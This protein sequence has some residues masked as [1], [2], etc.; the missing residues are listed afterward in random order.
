[1]NRINPFV[2]LCRK[3]E[4]DSI[5][6]C[7]SLCSKTCSDATYEQS[8]ICGN[9][10]IASRTDSRGNE[11]QKSTKQIKKELTKIKQ[12]LDNLEDSKRDAIEITKKV[13]L[14]RDAINKVNNNNNDKINKNDSSNSNNNNKNNNKRINDENKSQQS[15]YTESQTIKVCESSQ[16]SEYDLIN[17]ITKR[18]DLIKTLKESNKSLYKNL[19]KQEEKIT[20]LTRSLQSSQAQLRENRKSFEKYENLLEENMM[21]SM[22][23][24]EFQQ[25]LQ[26]KDQTNKKILQAAEELAKD[27][28]ERDDINKRLNDT[29]IKLEETI[30]ELGE[31]N[32][33]LIQENN[34]L[35][36]NIKDK[37]EKYL[38]IK[39]KYD[40]V[41]KKIDI[42]K[43]QMQK[44]QLVTSECL[45]NNPSIYIILQII[46][47]KL[48]D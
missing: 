26:K 3:V 39:N 37:E 5:R 30:I 10:L 40:N 48:V 18:D 34:E 11:K 17:K 41:E 25:S 47:R 33:K 24:N 35:C 6:T 14:K 13:I 2:G 36:N 22:K 42:F 12:Q 21:L 28:Q 20:H 19:K 32:K 8:L 4:E 27:L 7:E 46:L 15:T 23:M 9:V 43:D 1:M 38:Q 16:T 29:V 45:R 44:S 31:M